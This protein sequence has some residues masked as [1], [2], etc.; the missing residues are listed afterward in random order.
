MSACAAFSLTPSTCP[1]P[2]S[3]TPS[4]YSSGCRARSRAQRHR[5]GG[6]LHGLWDGAD[7]V[8]LRLQANGVDT[9][10]TVSTNG[11]FRFDD[12]LPP[13]RSYT[14]TVATNPVQHTCVVDGGGNGMMAEADVTSVSIACTGPAE[15]VP[16]AEPASPRH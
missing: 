11:S 4:G 9:L 1:T 3:V 10:L 12:P 15:R 2:R 7:G 5:V 8:S 16:T 14:V 6:R 13:G